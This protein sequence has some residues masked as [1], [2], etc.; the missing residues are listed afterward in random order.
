MA[1][2]TTQQE[3]E[4]VRGVIQALLTAGTATVTMTSLDGMAVQYSQDQLPM[5]Q[6]REETLAKRLSSRNLRKR[7]TPDF[8]H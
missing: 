3:Y 7:T 2:L 1:T 5:L 6:A 4:L 8:S